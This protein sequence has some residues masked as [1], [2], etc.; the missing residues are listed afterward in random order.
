MVNFG[1]LL[2]SLGHPAHFN[3]FCVLACYCMALWQWASG[4]SRPR[5]HCVWWGPAPQKGHGP[6]NVR[7]MS[8]MAKRRS[9]QLLLLCDS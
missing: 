6:F 8:I 3:G 9:S 5:R 2:A 1:P 7:P 4:R